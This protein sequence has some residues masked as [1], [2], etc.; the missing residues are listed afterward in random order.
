MATLKFY[1]SEQISNINFLVDRSRDVEQSKYLQAFELECTYNS[2]D[3]VDPYEN[4]SI[5][6]P[7]KIIKNLTSTGY[8]DQIL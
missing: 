1:V 3:I 8:L 2:S 7:A 6:V 5:N 4:I